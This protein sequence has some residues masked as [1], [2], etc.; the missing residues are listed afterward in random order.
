[1]EAFKQLFDITEKQ[2]QEIIHEYDQEQTIE[3][4][5]CFEE[6]YVSSIINNDLGIGDN[7][8]LIEAGQKTFLMNTKDGID[9]KK[10]DIAHF[11]KTFNQHLYRVAALGHKLAS[12]NLLNHEVFSDTEELDEE[13]DETPTKDEPIN[14]KEESRKKRNKKKKQKPKKPYL[15]KINRIYDVLYH[16]KLLFTSLYSIKTKIISNNFSSQNSLGLDRFSPLEPDENTPYQNLIIFLMGKLQERGYRRQDDQCMA[17]VYTQNGMDTHAW[18]P[19]M[20][21]KRFVY[22]EAQ[23]LGNHEQW[24][25]LSC[26]PSNA[27]NAEKYLL[28]VDDPIHFPD[29]VKDR[30]LFSFKN[31]IYESDAYADSNGNHYDRWYPHLNKSEVGLDEFVSSDIPSERSACKY[32]D[33]DLPID[34]VKKERKDWY[35]IPTP[36]FQSILDYQKFSKDVSKWMYVFL[37]RL[38]YELNDLDAW[39]VMP[40]LLG[41]AKT[42]KSTILTAVCKLFFH[43]LDIGVLSNNCEKQFGLSALDGKFLFIAPEVK[44]NIGLE[45]TEFQSI[46]SGE[47]TN[48]ARKF[49]TAKGKVWTTPGILAGNEAPGYKDN[50]GSIS[51]RL[52]IFG[53]DRKVQRGDMRLSQK[54][55]NEIAHIL[56]KCNRAYLEASNNH[57][58]CD[59]WTVLPDYFLKTK[60]L[61][62]EQTN[63]L[64]N[65]LS[66]DRLRYGEG[67]Y[68]SK[69]KLAKAFKEYCKENSLTA[70][71]FT[72]EIWQG[73]FEEKHLKVEKKRLLDKDE[74]KKRRLD[75]VIGCDLDENVEESEFGASQSEVDLF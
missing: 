8:P 46:I 30:K 29:I 20:D 54:L 22:S 61:M 25:N 60:Q 7:A 24:K 55:K 50:Q 52:V 72:K 40:L 15:A 27:S 48:I 38:L 67:L 1:M 47:D 9:E 19:V 16:W 17:R 21:I 73:P 44:E 5:N 39:Q 12:E 3:L 14:D 26:V 43:Q 51:R 53:F 59:V 70:S 74:N 36:H 57:G 58:S 62:I 45:Q 28:N 66:S 34:E 13:V 41:K 56:L 42:G 64:I 23:L 75:W 69:Q 33:C 11:D 49:H 37:G 35:S 2:Y 6:H 10:H 68:C 63:S 65:F 32:F 71:K 31:G 4:L 18:Q